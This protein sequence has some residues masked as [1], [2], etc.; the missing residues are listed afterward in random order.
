MENVFSRLVRS[1]IPDDPQ[2]LRILLT[3][4][5]VGQM[6]DR[7][8]DGHRERDIRRQSEITAGSRH[9]CRCLVIGMGHQGQQHAL[10]SPLDRKARRVLT[11]GTDDSDGRVFFCPYET[12][13]VPDPCGRWLN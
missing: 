6:P 12:P 13:R 11:I 2:T 10:Q 5:W 3:A 9:A 8:D 4:R 1:R 7:I